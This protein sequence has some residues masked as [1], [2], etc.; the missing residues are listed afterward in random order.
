MMSYEMAW[1]DEDCN[2][3]V[4]FSI[5]YSIENSE[6]KIAEVTPVSVSF[7]C[8]DSGEVNRT[9]GVHTA[10]GRQHLVDQFSTPQRTEAMVN[11]IAEQAGLLV[12][13]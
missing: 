2:R 3:S 1:E 11:A 5:A 10:K 4:Q 13:A 8:P 6:V 7:L 9:V 12:S